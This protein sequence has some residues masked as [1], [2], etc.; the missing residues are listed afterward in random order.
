MFGTDLLTRSPT[1]ETQKPQWHLAGM[2]CKIAGS[3]SVSSTRVSVSQFPCL[4]AMFVDSFYIFAY[5]DPF[6]PLNSQISRPLSIPRY[7]VS[8]IHRAMQTLLVSSYTLR[9]GCTGD[10]GSWQ[11]YS[12]LRENHASKHFNCSLDKVLIFKSESSPEV[13]FVK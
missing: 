7:R 4:V 9:T 6:N 3:C 13:A 8:E 11:S 12:M 2:K 1:M 5:F 10:T